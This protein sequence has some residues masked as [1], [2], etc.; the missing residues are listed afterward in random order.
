MYSAGQILVADETA[1]DRRRMRKSV[2][3]GVRGEQTFATDSF[4]KRG[5]RVSALCF[6]SV[7][8]FEDWRFLLGPHTRIHSRH[9]RL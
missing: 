4:P 2:G 1:K 6:F 3:W 7:L 5:R 9:P 8:G